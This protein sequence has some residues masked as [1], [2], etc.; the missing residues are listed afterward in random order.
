MTRRNT[1]YKYL[2]ERYGYIPYVWKGT[3][4]EVLDLREEI[5]RD[6]NSFLEEMRS[7][8]E[9][10]SDL[11]IDDEAGMASFQHYEGSGWQQRPSVTYEFDLKERSRRICYEGKL[12]ED[13]IP[14]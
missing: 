7:Y 5:L 1:F 2:K 13:W 8:G 12:P 6:I 9:T 11:K 3:T 4:D 14:W 10:F